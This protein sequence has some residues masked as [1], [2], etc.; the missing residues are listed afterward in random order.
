MRRCWLVG[1]GKFNKGVQLPCGVLAIAAF[2]RG[3]H[4]ACR[5][6][7]LIPDYVSV[8]LLRLRALW[9]EARFR[10]D[11]AQWRRKTLAL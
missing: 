8:I 7:G 3:L 5:R 9:R 1:A 6:F 11:A 10:I 4:P 2:K